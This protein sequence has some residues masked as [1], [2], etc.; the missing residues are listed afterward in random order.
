MALVKIATYF[1][2]A[3]EILDLEEKY[4]SKLYLLPDHKWEH[5]IY[6]KLSPSSCP[7]ALLN[8]IAAAIR[9]MS[10]ENWYWVLDHLGIFSSRRILFCMPLSWNT[11]GT[12]NRIKTADTLIQSQ[13]IDLVDRFALACNYWCWHEIEEFWKEYQTM[14]TK[15]F[16]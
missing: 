10:V 7:T 2:R 1:I 12:I 4:Q 14:N 15:Q 3:P 6:Q 5:V 8:D 16:Y 11:D 13:G 9:A